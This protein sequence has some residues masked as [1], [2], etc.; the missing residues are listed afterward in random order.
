VP[1]RGRSFM[2]I[3]SFRCRRNISL[4]L[5]AADAE[6][7]LIGTCT[8]I[9]AITPNISFRCSHWFSLLFLDFHFDAFWFSDII[10]LII[11]IFI[12]I[13]FLMIRCQLHFRQPMHYFDWFTSIIG[14]C[15]FD[16]F[17]AAFLHFD[18]FWY[19]LFSWFRLI[20]SL[21]FWFSS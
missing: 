8:C 12:S 13:I 6:L 14:W 4:Q 20:F 19:F 16:Y 1:C 3:I 15:A 5:D 9:F 2:L 18:V 7:L 21:S 11:S 17:S 10:L